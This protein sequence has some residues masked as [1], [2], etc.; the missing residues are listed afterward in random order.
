MHGQGLISQGVVQ[1]AVRDHMLDPRPR[2][3]IGVRRNEE[4]ER[5]FVIPSI[6]NS[7]SR[8]SG[9]SSQ[10]HD[11]PA[12]LL[13]GRLHRGAEFVIYRRRGVAREMRITLCG[14]DDFVT[15][16]FADHLE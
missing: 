15:E 5:L 16:Q 1:G 7:G 4:N 12:R 11:L 14:G 13:D 6:L 2:D 10:P 9:R 3:R 8:P